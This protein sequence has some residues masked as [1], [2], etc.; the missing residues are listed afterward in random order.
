LS[1][2]KKRRKKV[3]KRIL[4][5]DDDDFIRNLIKEFLK[6]IMQKDSNIYTTSNGKEAL[7]ILENKKIDLIIS[8]VEM[9]VMDGRELLKELEKNNNKTNVIIM[10]GTS[11]RSEFS[12]FK[13]VVGFL[14]KPFGIY[15]LA[16]LICK[17]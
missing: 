17:K 12:D 16:K 9:P 11:C 6:E 13:N 4:V 7:E 8:D 1:K 10:S 3:D 14:E 5:V 15:E 2:N